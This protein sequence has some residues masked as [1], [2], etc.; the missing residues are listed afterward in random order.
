MVS[1]GR[2]F[3]AVM[4]R[5]RKEVEQVV[6]FVL[7]LVNLCLCP[8]VEVMVMGCLNR[9]GIFKVGTNFGFVECKESVVVLLAK[10]AF[11]CVDYSGDF[12]CD[13]INVV[14]KVEFVVDSDAQHAPLEHTVDYISPF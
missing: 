7:C 9:G 10:F 12:V 4:M 11:D 14:G 8:Q 5:C 1:A 2:E 6:V 3:H 13:V